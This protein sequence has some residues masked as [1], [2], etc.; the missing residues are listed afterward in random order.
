MTGTKGA[1]LEEIVRAYFD[2]QGFFALRSVPFRYGHD[3][4]TDVDIWLYARPSAGVRTKGVVDVKNKKSPRALERVLWTKGLQAIL[5]ADVATVVTTDNNPR[6]ARFGQEHRVAVLSKALLD[7]LQKSLNLDDRLSLEELLQEIRSYSAQKTDGDWIKRLEETKSGLISLSN[8]PAL[9]RA[10]QSFA[11]FAERIETRPHF[12]APALRCSLISAAV[13]C[14]ALDAALERLTFE[15]AGDRHRAI[16]DGVRYGD[17]GDSRTQKS[18]QNVLALIEESME[19]GRVV[20]LEA[21][22][23]IDERFKAIRAEILADHFSREHNSSQL[24]QIARELEGAA[25]HKPGPAPA[26]LSIDARAVLG[27]FA[28]FVQ[29]RR[30]LILGASVP[31]IDRPK[32]DKLQPPE[33]P[34]TGKLL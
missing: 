19:N 24:V 1:S 31:E 13:G 3:D 28:D 6:V 29:I 5:G 12:A 15:D 14:V 27:V 11:F 26:S 30:Q 34:S 25:H 18:I 22:S 32:S 17:S 33:E 20:A 21:R 8:F 16:L 23:R 10:L 9:N 2:R 7:R 4:V